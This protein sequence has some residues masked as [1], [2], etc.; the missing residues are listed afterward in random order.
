M[1]NNTPKV[2][3]SYQ[4]ARDYFERKGIYILFEHTKSSELEAQVIDANGDLQVCFVSIDKN[5]GD[6]GNL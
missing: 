4:A 1:L 3:K 5:G 6:A 2:F